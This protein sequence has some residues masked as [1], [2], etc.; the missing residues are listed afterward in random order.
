V[1]DTSHDLSIA[2][3]GRPWRYRMSLTVPDWHLTSASQGQ[4]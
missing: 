1:N 2:R 4:C 3:V